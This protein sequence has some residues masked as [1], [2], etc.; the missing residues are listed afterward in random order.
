VNL[1]FKQE[2]HLQQ[3]MHHHP[4]HRLHHQQSTMIDY[5][6]LTFQ[7]VELFPQM[8]SSKFFAIFRLYLRAAMAYGNEPALPPHIFNN[9]ESATAIK[10]EAELKQ[11]VEKMCAD[12]CLNVNDPQIQKLI[13]DMVNA[14]LKS[15]H[16]AD[17]SYD[18]GMSQIQVAQLRHQVKQLYCAFSPRMPATQVDHFVDQ[19]V[20]AYMD[21]RNNSPPSPQSNNL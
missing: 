3:S 2:L 13:C 10:T 17:V 8:K 20:M 1:N 9:Q 16:N 15:Q 6:D 21:P 7:V 12:Y 14:A 11:D 18:L 4:F 19:L 5:K